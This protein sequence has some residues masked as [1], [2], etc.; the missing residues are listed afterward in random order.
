MHFGKPQFDD[1]VGYA[2]ENN[3]CLLDMTA[4]ER[5]DVRAKRD[6]D[7]HAGQTAFR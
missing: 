6:A 7:T 5:A 4:G 3:V 2:C 1:A